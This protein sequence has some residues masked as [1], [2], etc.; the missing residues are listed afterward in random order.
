[1]D[2]S[3]NQPSVDE[4][5]QIWR[6]VIVGE[7]K[8]WVLLE[9]GTCVIFS[10]ATGDLKKQ[11]RDLLAEWGPVHVGTP[12]GDFNVVKL[13]NHPGWVVTCHHPDI[14]TYVDPE[15]VGLASSDLMI[16]LI[17]RSKRDQDALEL[18]VVHVEHGGG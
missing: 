10:N 15:D 4:L 11:A 3:E 1:M 2:D 7:K 17:G 6:S 18:K 12:A 14:L 13:A 5:V 9:H 8:S 16:G